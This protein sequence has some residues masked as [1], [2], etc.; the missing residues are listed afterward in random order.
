MDYLVYI[1]IPIIIVVILLMLI[2]LEKHERKRIFKPKKYSEGWSYPMHGYYID[3]N[4]MVTFESDKVMLNGYI[5]GENNTNGLVI[6]VHSMHV[7]SDYYI[8][9]ALFLAKEGFKVFMYDT[10]GFWKNEGKFTGFKRAVRDLEN[11]I[12]YIDDGSMPISIM[13]HGMG[14]YAAISVLNFTK[15]KIANVISVAAPY[16]EK[17]YIK[18]KMSGVKGV[19]VSMLQN[20]SNRKYYKKDVIDGINGCESKDTFF[21]IIHG[22]HDE[23]VNYSTLSIQSRQ[24]AITNKNVQFMLLEDESDTHMGIVRPDKER[25]MVNEEIL[26]YVTELF[27]SC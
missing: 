20:A 10:T 27:Y 9:E 19:L 7:P 21:C 1:L 13:G 6:I 2:L 3:E 22:K 15:K 8:P 14:G 11:A 12:E 16:S 25:P 26:G 17:A 23:E 4:K 18:S 5:Y 24:E